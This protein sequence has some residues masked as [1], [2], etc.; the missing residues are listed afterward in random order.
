MPELAYLA[1]PVGA[2]ASQ[3]DGDG[4][5]AHCRSYRDMRD[6]DIQREDHDTGG[7]WGV[8]DHNL[9]TVDRENRKHTTHGKA[10]SRELLDNVDQ[11]I[12]LMERLAPERGLI[13]N[14]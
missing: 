4:Y 7:M 1:Q 12:H 10:P 11:I 14:V 2:K 5:L 6:G 3:Q 13:R 9:V 8:Y